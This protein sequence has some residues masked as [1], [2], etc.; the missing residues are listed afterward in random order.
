MNINRKTQLPENSRKRN[1]AVDK[2]DAEKSGE[3]PNIAFAD[4]DKTF[5]VLSILCIP[6]G[7]YFS[8][9]QSCVSSSEKYLS[10]MKYLRFFVMD[11]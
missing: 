5:F 9:S 3:S 8:V 11:L 6:T 2:P 4:L 1:D 7:G 10:S